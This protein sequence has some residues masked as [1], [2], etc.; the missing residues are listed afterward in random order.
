MVYLIKK[1]L[2][3]FKRKPKEV[4]FFEVWLSPTRTINL[5]TGETAISGEWE[6]K[7]TP[8]DMK[9]YNKAV[10]AEINEMTK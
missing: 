6:H 8:T 5:E 4:E 7:A 9:V 2:S 10:K 3:L 1:L